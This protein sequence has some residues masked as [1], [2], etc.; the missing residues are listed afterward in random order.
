MFEDLEGWGDQL[1]ASV[2]GTLFDCSRAWAFIF[3][4]SIPM[5]LDFLSYCE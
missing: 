4:D 2:V 5:F 3:S 1:L